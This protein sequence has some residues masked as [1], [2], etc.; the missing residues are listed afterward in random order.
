MVGGW[1]KD[2]RDG[3]MIRRREEGERTGEER[4]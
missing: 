4:G 1:V 2:E 3:R